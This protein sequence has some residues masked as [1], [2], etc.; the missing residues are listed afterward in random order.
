MLNIRSRYVL[1]HDCLPLCR[2]IQLRYLPVSSL[3]VKPPYLAYFYLSSLIPNNQVLIDV[4]NV[5]SLVS[6]MIAAVL[7]M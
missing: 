1:W 2:T 3:E 4:S 5:I 6:A 7:C